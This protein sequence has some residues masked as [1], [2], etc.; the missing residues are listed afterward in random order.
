MNYVTKFTFEQSTSQCGHD[1]SMLLRI[2]L[3]FLQVVYL[4]INTDE[5]LFRLTQIPLTVDKFNNIL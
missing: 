3:L 4:F 5:Q 2:M 1:F